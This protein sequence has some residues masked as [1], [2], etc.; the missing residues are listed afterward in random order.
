MDETYSHSANLEECGSRKS[1]FEKENQDEIL[2]YSTLM[3][4]LI[5]PELVAC[6]LFK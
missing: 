2:N 6:P 1:V 4:T 5:P 3:Y